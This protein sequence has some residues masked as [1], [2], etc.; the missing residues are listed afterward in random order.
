MP[1]GKGSTK[2]VT[3][4]GQAAQYIEGAWSEKGWVDNGEHQLHWQDAEGVLYDLMG[5]NL[6]LEELLAVAESIK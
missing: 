2:E 3:V 6:G 1:A 5:S 4:N